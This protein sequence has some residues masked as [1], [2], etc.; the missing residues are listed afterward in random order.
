MK[1]RGVMAVGLGLSLAFGTLGNVSAAY[2]GNSTDYEG[3]WAQ[4]QIERWLQ[5]GWL[6]GFEDGSVR[7][8]QEITRAEFITF[9]NRIWDIRTSKPATFSDLPK[10][11]WAYAEFSKAMS[12]GYIKGYEGKI[13]PND[14]ITRQEAAVIISRLNLY[15][16]GSPDRGRVV[17]R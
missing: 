14:L 3:H 16:D 6:K 13:R 7:P 2:D 5:H 4:K 12:A 8:D 15:E 11:D 9:A 17:C 1:F 10:T